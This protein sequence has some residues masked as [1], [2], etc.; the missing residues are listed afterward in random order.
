MCYSHEI[1]YYTTEG[2]EIGQMDLGGMP[3]EMIKAIVL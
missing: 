2:H 1:H 3:S